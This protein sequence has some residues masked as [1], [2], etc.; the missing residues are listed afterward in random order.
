MRPRGE[1]ARLR[2]SLHM[3]LH[4]GE[5]LS[6][7]VLSGEFL[8]CMEKLRAARCDQGDAERAGTGDEQE[9]L[10]R[11]VWRRDPESRGNGRARLILVGVVMTI[12]LG[13]VLQVRLGV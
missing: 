3:H 5:M 12:C 8:Y 9:R 13:W 4:E 11:N 10:D 1:P 7:P 6:C 2:P